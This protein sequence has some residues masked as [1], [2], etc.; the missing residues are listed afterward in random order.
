MCIGDVFGWWTIVSEEGVNK[1]NKKQVLCRCL[2]GFEKVLEVYDLSGRKTEKC[3]KC[4]KEKYKSKIDIPGYKNAGFTYDFK[5]QVR[6][7]SDKT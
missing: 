4:Q 7:S 5:Y 1:Y 2:C 6:Y 3:R